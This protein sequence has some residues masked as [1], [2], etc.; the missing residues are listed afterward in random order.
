MWVSRSAAKKS[1]HHHMP[2]ASFSAQYRHFL[3]LG[4]LCVAAALL[5]VS[6]R[7]NIDW[8]KRHLRDFEHLTYRRFEV[9]EHMLGLMPLLEEQLGEE[10][11]PATVRLLA[12]LHLG[13][14]EKAVLLHE[15]GNFFLQHNKKALAEGYF[16]RAKKK[17]LR[18]RHG[19]RWLAEHAQRDFLTKANG[20]INLRCLHQAKAQV[21]VARYYLLTAEK[22]NLKDQALMNK[23]SHWCQSLE[24][25][26]E[27]GVH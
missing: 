16:S 2:L 26:I 3:A 25:R 6:E 27:G 13:A 15:I 12:N 17:L 9:A 10:M 18:D 8:L 7:S 4:N 5:S 19:A 20:A 11:N 1:H 22:S 24:C 14:R 23:L 21:E